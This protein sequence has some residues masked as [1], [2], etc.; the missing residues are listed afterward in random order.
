MNSIVDGEAKATEGTPEE[1]STIGIQLRR[2]PLKDVRVEFYDCA[3]Q[4]DYKGMHQIFLTRAL[5]LVV[6]NVKKCLGKASST[7][8]EVRASQITVCKASSLLS[9]N[10]SNPRSYSRL[11]LRNMFGCG[12]QDACVR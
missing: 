5:Y 8:D 12:F 4:I 7:L 11:K 10:L 9:L 2:H 3:G 1:V 6:W